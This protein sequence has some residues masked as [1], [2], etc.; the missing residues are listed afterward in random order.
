MYKANNLLQQETLV[1][2][3]LPE[4]ILPHFW[5]LEMVNQLVTLVVNITS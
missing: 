4:T 1:G 5:Y 3:I 2:I